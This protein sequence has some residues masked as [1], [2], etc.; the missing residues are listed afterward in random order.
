MK[1]RPGERKRTVR[2]SE[3]GVD[4]RYREKEVK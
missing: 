1:A 4:G 3:R 2:D